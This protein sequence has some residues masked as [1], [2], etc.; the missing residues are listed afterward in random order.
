VGGAYRIRVA[1][2][3]RKRTE[4]NHF[5]KKIFSLHLFFSLSR[6]S[7]FSFTHIQLFIIQAK[8]YEVSGEPYK[9]PVVVRRPSRR[10][11]HRRQKNISFFL[12]KNLFSKI[13]FGLDFEN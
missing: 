8:T 9:I 7:I 2:M 4:T 3:Y 11:H 12:K 1:Y 5:E 6:F 13:L 10:R